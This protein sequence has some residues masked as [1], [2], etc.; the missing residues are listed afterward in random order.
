[1]KEG[2]GGEGEEEGEE[3]EAGEE[4]EGEGEEHFSLQQMFNRAVV[5]SR[6]C[7]E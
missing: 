6:L 1:M 7:H 2:G 3:G 4:E 5:S